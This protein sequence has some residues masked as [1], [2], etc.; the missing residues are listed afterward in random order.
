MSE[1]LRLM[2]RVS[3]GGGSFSGVAVAF[4]YLVLR[5]LL[6]LA[7]LAVVGHSCADPGAWR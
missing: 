3:A 4:L 6:E 2:G 7:V 5:R 1:G